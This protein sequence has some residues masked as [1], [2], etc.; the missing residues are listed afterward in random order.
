M[1][2]LESLTGIAWSIGQ[3]SVWSSSSKAGL[4]SSAKETE[5]AEEKFQT[6]VLEVN[7][8]EVRKAS[9]FIDSRPFAILFF[10]V[11]LSLI[12]LLRPLCIALR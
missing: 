11:N 7:S 12:G 5:A 1:L 10:G 8:F 3:I 2:S 6:L 9:A 4:Q